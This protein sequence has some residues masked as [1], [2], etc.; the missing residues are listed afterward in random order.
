[1]PPYDSPAPIIPHRAVVGKKYL[2]INVIIGAIPVKIKKHPESSGKIT[3][4]FF[5]EEE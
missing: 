5:L 1:V 2:Y 3:V 4:F